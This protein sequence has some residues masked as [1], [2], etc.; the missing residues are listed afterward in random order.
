[1]RYEASLGPNTKQFWLY[2]NEKNVYID[3]PIDVLEKAEEIRWKDGAETA[4]SISDAEAYLED[5]A[6]NENPEWLHDGYEY[7]ADELEP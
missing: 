3:P 2:D 4:D 7:D 1:M 5:L 6:N